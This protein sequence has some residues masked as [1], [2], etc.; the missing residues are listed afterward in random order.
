MHK[1]HLFAHHCD[2]C[3]KHCASLND[4]TLT[5]SCAH[6]RSTNLL[7]NYRPLE[8]SLQSALKTPVCYFKH[9]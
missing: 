7:T 3:I 1:I 2:Q 4:N 6:C 5:F 8:M 9:S